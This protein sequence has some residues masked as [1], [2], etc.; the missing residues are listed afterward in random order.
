MQFL[1]GKYFFPKRNKYAS[2]R[3]LILNIEQI[4]YFLEVE[5]FNSF[6][7]AAE[8]LC[9]SQSSLSKQIKALEKELNTLLFNRSTRNVTLSPSGEA[10]LDYAK[11]YLNLHNKIIKEMKNHCS[12]KSISIGVMPLIAQYGVIHLISSFNKKFPN[13]NVNLMEKDEDSLSEL[14]NSS[15]IDLAF[16]N[17]FNID[18][19]L[20]NIV[21][22]F[23]DELV[24]VVSKNN[25]LCNKNN[26]SI[27]DLQDETFILLNS[28][29]TIY[30]L[31]CNECLKAG[32][33]P[34]TSHTNCR[35]ETIMELVSE[36]LGIT[37]L[38]KK[39]VEY[40]NNPNLKI[41][42]LKNKPKSKI[43]LISSKDKVIS[44]ESK[45]FIDFI[46]N[47][48]LSHK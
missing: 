26:I 37:L 7:L 28:N 1:L 8:E 47:C 41:V 40:F 38:T 46:T 30:N 48:N 44:N 11:E 33:A 32:F 16:T 6:T 4:H 23:T 21:P 34:K 39:V 43:A 17:T 5:K 20:Y 24:L 35:I 18:A 25:P 13:I 29:A 9:I 15:T 10:F 3:L 22:V 14:F 2:R 19:N 12:N 45:E 36:N 31:C 27:C 42:S